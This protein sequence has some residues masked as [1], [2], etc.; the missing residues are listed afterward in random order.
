MEML[1]LIQF[2]LLEIMIL[3]MPLQL[4][5]EMLVLGRDSLCSWE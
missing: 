4:L 3:V 5:I 2:I 1:L